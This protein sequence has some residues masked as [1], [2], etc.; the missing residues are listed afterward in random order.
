MGKSFE[1]KYFSSENVGKTLNGIVD[2]WDK[3]AK[4]VEGKG[5]VIGQETYDAFE[6]GYNKSK[7]V[8]MGPYARLAYEDSVKKTKTR[9]VYD[10]SGNALFNKYNYEKNRWVNF[11]NGKYE[12]SKYDKSEEAKLVRNILKKG[13]KATAEEMEFV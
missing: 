13:R 2:Y 7:V 4:S 10:Q 1:R 3:M 6:P 11:A 8:G 12:P 9:N 5:K